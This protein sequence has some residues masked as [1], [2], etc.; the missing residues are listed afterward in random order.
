[1]LK[2][3]KTGGEIGNRWKLGVVRMCC[4]GVKARASWEVGGMG[5][6]EIILCLICT[7]YVT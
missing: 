1:M 5:S 3:W 4:D 2:G 6:W 7:G